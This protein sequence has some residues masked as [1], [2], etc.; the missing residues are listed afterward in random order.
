MKWYEG[1]KYVYQK[2]Q[3]YSYRCTNHVQQ[4]S[5]TIFYIA[6]D[7]RTRYTWKRSISQICTRIRKMKQ[8]EIENCKVNWI[9]KS[10]LI[11]CLLEVY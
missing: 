2:H 8:K 9:L 4:G 6:Y 1:I 10:L 7:Y 3:L 5:I 11:E